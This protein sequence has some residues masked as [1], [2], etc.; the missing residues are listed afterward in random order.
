MPRAL[1]GLDVDGVLADL[2]GRLL[3][4]VY[5]RTGQRFVREQVTQFSLQAVLGDEI[6]TVASDALAEPGFASSLQLIE[7]AREGVERLRTLGRV[8]FV[9]SPYLRSATWAAERTH[10]L[11]RH[12]GARQED[13]VNT[14][15]KTLFAGEILV[16]DAPQNLEAWTKT[17]R[18]AVRAVQPWNE[19]APGLP[20]KGWPAIADA[21]DALLASEL[22]RSKMG[23]AAVDDLR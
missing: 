1:I 14:A 4:I 21:V 8:V 12:L 9:T 18:Y 2:V 16:D 23:D 22:E 20:A 11:I 17:G 3:Q 7:G 13:I 19:H 6:W 10:W 5:E 15:D